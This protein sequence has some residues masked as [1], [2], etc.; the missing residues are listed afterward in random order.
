MQI[1]MREAIERFI[2]VRNFEE[3]FN[4]EIQQEVIQHSM[5]KIG[6]SKRCD[7]QSDGEIREVLYNN[8]RK[9]KAESVWEFIVNK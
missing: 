5:N 2:P 7:L 6:I 4:R 8:F 9:D 3:A 1:S